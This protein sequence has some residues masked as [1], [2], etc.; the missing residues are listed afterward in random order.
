MKNCFQYCYDIEEITLP[1]SVTT[2]GNECFSYCNNLSKI[3]G[4]EHIKVFGEDCFS[5]S[6]YKIPN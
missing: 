3:E 1:Q 4:I 2:L 5:Y 6:P